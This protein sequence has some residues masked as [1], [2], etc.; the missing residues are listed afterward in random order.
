MNNYTLSLLYTEALKIN[1]IFNL[2]MFDIIT[3]LKYYS[4][5]IMA[6]SR[7]YRIYSIGSFDK[8]IA[9]LITILL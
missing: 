7:S 8:Y 6:L 3:D 2:I 9:S 5:T 4:Q 1:L